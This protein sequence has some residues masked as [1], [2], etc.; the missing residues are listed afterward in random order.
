VSSKTKKALASYGRSFV[1]AALATFL[2]TGGDIFALNADGLKA[3]VSAG[4]AAL[5][6]VAL[7]WAN[8]NDEAFGRGA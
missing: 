8:P 5:L 2:A 7:R 3:I 4:V 1:G 6:P